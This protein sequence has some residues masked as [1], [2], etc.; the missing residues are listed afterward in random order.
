MTAPTFTLVDFFTGGGMVEAA[1]APRF[2]CAFANDINPMKARVHRANFPGGKLVVRDVATLTPPD[3]PTADLAWA[4]SPCQDLSLAGARSGL[5]GARSGTLWAF[6][7]QMRS[8]VSAGRAPPLIAIENVVGLLTSG[9]GE[10][11]RALCALLADLGYQ[12]GHVVL[13]AIDFLPQS[14]PRVFVVASRRGFPAGMVDDD[15]G[16]L[17]L[18]A[19]PARNVQLVDLLEPDSAVAWHSAQE[20]QRHLDMLSAANRAKLDEM[21]R[22]DQRLAGTGFRRMRNGVQRFEIRFDAAG[23]LRVASGG[24]SRQQLILVDGDKVRTRLLTPRECARLMG[25]PDDYVLPTNLNDALTLIGDGVAVPCVRWL[26]RH[27][28]EP[29]LAEFRADLGAEKP[30]A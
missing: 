3:I 8:L 2:E 20:T 14:R 15:D 16:R 17:Q 30:A 7:A 28:L 19:P 23:C 29:L 10:D 24:S 26:A 27:V 13:D 9:G 4:S 22:L 25:L 18:P 6:L 5:A 21:Q 11:F 12:V 1:L